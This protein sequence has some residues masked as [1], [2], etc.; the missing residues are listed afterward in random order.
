MD[1]IKDL[2]MSGDSL[3]EQLTKETMILNQSFN[4]QEEKH[5]QVGPSKQSLVVPNTPGV[6]FRL[7]EGPGI[8]CLRGVAVKSLSSAFLSFQNQ[9]VKVLEALKIE[10]ALCSLEYF[11]TTSIA[12]AEIIRDNFF[13]RRF[14]REDDVL[15]NFGDANYHWWLVEDDTFCR[16]YF[17][18]NNLIS[19]ETNTTKLGPLSDSNVAYRR[20]LD[21]QNLL[22]SSCGPYE[23]LCNEKFLEIRYQELNNG[24]FWIKDLFL[25]GDFKNIPEV[26]SVDDIDRETFYYYLQELACARRFWIKIDSLINKDLSPERV[27]N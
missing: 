16:I 8:F 5:D 3:F 14:P 27:L 25:D 15:V 12:Q 23:Y 7:E 17:K 18:N 21:N 11:E 1:W 19:R 4:C 26:S 2:E 10:N 22:R 13:N 6:L 20:F 24:N 9:D